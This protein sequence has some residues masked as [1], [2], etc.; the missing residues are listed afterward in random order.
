MLRYTGDCVEWSLNKQQFDMGG[1][2]WAGNNMIS[3][4]SSWR[5]GGGGGERERERE[6]ERDVECLFI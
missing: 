2:P 4:D 5:E 6:R 1:V 3:I